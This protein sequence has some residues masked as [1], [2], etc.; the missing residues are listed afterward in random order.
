MTPGDKGVW[1]VTGDA[2]WKNKFY[3]FDVEVYVNSTGKVEHNVVTDPYSLG[4]AMNSTRSMIVDL[5]DP[6][7]K[8]SAWGT[9]AKPPLA[10]PEDIKLYELHV[11]DF[12]I[13]DTT[14]PEAARGTFKAFT[15]PSSNGM[16]HLK[17]LAD[18]GLTHVH[19]LPVFDIA[20]INENKAERVEPDRA[21]PRA[22]D[23]PDQQAGSHG[24]G[25][26]GRLQ[27]GL[28]P[29][30]LHRARRLATPR[31]RRRHAHRR[32]PRDG[33][34]AARIRPARGDGRGLQPHARLGPGRHVGARQDRPRLLPPPQRRRRGGDQHLLRQ[35][36]QRARHVREAD[37]RL[38]GDLGIASTRWT[39][40]AST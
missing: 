9:V 11:R 18:A 22:P 34:G 17:A 10:A 14:V 25:R 3:L 15:Y 16:V 39:A 27:L 40:S 37:G 30:S 1:S 38:A 29:V 19:L 28:R 21:R 26:P 12:S 4:L 8:P 20:T 33:A 35:H 2:A 6:A 36:G 13:N 5:N 24:R 23:S 32:V 31:T 7:L